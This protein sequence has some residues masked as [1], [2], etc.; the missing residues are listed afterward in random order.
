MIIY[1]I[2]FLVIVIGTLIFKEMNDWWYR[3]KQF[4]FVLLIFC[5]IWV[6]IEILNSINSIYWY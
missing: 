4:L 6:L 2:G 1:I 3:W 5:M